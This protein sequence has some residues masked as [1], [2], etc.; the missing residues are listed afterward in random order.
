MWCE[1]AK[2]AMGRV[3][4]SLDV[5]QLRHVFARGMC[6]CRPPRKNHEMCHM[7]GYH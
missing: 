4:L 2:G 3:L 6:T 1:T 7:I 5:R